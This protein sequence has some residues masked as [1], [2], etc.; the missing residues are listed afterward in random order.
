MLE[1]TLGYEVKE[2]WDEYEEYYI[3]VQTPGVDY[4]TLE[5]T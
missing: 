4:W 3:G 1:C 2:E 5:N